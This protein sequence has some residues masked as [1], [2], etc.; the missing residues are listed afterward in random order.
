MKPFLQYFLVLL[1]LLFAHN[2]LSQDIIYKQ[3]GGTVTGKIVE[4][5]IDNII[6]TTTTN[7]EIA[8][9]KSDIHKIIYQ[10]GKEELLNA[11]GTAP[12]R[13]ATAT[14][15]PTEPK[16]LKVSDKDNQ[17]IGFDSRKVAY[18][19]I[20]LGTAN[21]LRDAG[22][23]AI[24]NDKA[25]YA[26]RGFNFNLEAGYY[27]SK[28]F[29]AGAKIF[30]TVNER[31]TNA[32]SRNAKTLFVQDINAGITDGSMSFTNE[33]FNTYV[34]ASQLY[35]NGALLG[36]KGCLP[37]NRLSIELWLWLG[38]AGTTIDKIDVEHVVVY[39]S[40][41]VKISSPDL[42][43]SGLG[44]GF[45]FS[46]KYDI[47]KRLFISLQYEYLSHRAS[48]SSYNSTAYFSLDDQV[49]NLPQKAQT[50]GVASSNISLGLGF[51][52]RKK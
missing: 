30:S 17:K 52:F 26:T 19:A 6:Y 25:L 15:A 46:V 3:D 50:V 7:Q 24:N 36:L 42:S 4:I 1:T 21:P 22:S 38:Y 11:I 28:Y 37:L 33:D 39:N 10:N 20:H 44:M 32:M 34:T 12:Q 27:F 23:E 8:M 40:N 13:E 14:V 51:V 31:N 48:Y 47:F 29:A 16:P 9:K 35:F 5:G 18:I 41:Y 45:D 2:L 49:V 43:S